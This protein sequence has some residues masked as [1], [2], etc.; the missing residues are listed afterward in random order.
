VNGQTI[1][2]PDGTS[3]SVSEGKVVVGGS[4]RFTYRDEVKVEIT[5]NPGSVTTMSGDVSVTGSVTGS[6]RTMSGDVT[7]GPV[8]GGVSTMSGDIRH[9]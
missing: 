1:E 3:I 2:V 7:C 6:V 4:T 5:G 8:G 9:G